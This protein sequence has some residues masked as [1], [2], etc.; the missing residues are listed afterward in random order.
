MFVFSSFAV[1]N[2]VLCVGSKRAPRT[3]G[4]ERRKGGLLLLHTGLMLMVLCCQ[5]DAGEPGELGSK[6]EKGERVSCQSVL[7]LWPILESVEVCST[8]QLRKDFNVYAWYSKF[9][10]LMLKLSL[11]KRWACIRENTF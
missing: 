9:L 10:P 11:N 1:C 7:V 5:G 4:S 3:D 2:F 6:G 8:Y